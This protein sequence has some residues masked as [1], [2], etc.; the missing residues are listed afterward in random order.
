MH[1]SQLLRELSTLPLFR[2]LPPRSLEGLA[3]GTVKVAKKGELL[4]RSGDRLKQTYLLLGGEVEVQVPLQDGRM[5]TKRARPGDLL[6][7][8]ALFSHDAEALGTTTCLSSCRLLPLNPK[9]FD[10]TFDQAAVRAIELALLE[11][12]SS[13]LQGSEPAL[14]APAESATLMGKLLALFGRTP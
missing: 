12:F 10:E 9:D 5:L 2:T 3:G 14:E 7:R 8:A 6:L 11:S 4:A 13:V 1:E